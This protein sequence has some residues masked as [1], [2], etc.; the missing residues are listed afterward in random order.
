[1]VAMSAGIKNLVKKRAPWVFQSIKSFVAWSKIQMAKPN[2][3]R[4]N[5]EHGE[6]WLN[7]AAGSQKGTNGWLTL[8]V[9]PGCDIYWDLRYGIPFPNERVSKIYASHFMEHLS[10]PDGQGFLDECLRVLKPGGTISL[11]VPNARLYLEAYVNKTPIESFLKYEPAVNH[12]T[13][14]DCVNYMAYMDDHHKYMF[15]EENLVHILKAKGFKNAR[16][17]AFDPKLDLQMR[18]YE[19]LYAEAEK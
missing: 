9:S 6:I 13:R 10:Y 8:D 4:L 3:R 14:I 15:D 5:K 7:V 17:R 19:S 2:V 11:A 12:T 1:M 16:L 18:D